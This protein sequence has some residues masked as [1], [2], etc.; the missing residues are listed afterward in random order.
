[1][2][3]M[4]AGLAET[5]GLKVG[6]FLGQKL[7]IGACLP[8]TDDDFDDRPFRSAL[9]ADKLPRSVDLRRWMT[10]VEAQGDIGSCTSNALGSA[11]EYLIYRQTGTVADVSRLFL[12]Y[13]QRLFR[14]KVREDPGSSI[15]LAVRVASRLGVPHEGMWPYHPDLFAVQPPDAVY[16]AALEHR[17]VDYSRVPV[18]LHS[19]RACLAGGFPLAFGANLFPSSWEHTGKTGEVKMPKPGEKDD[20]G[21]AMLMVG[22]DDAERV[23]VVRNSWGP[24]WGDGG[25]CYVPFDYLMNPEWVRPFWMIRLASDVTFEEAEHARVDLS[26]LPKA[27]PRPNLLPATDGFGSLASA[28]SA[29]E[30][31][32]NIAAGVATAA[33]PA[34][35]TALTG[36]S[37]AGSLLGGV[38]KGL[39]PALLSGPL[40]PGAL[41]EHDRTETIL[42]L[43]RGAGSP[44]P[45]PNARAS[46]DDGFDEQAVVTGVRKRA[47]TVDVP[48]SAEQALAAPPPQVDDTLRSVGWDHP[49]TLRF[50]NAT[51]STVYVYWVDTDGRDRPYF[52]LL[53]SQTC[54][55]QTYDGHPWRIRDASGQL[56]LVARGGREPRIVTV[57]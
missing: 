41:A 30:R 34:L 1:M 5:L 26:R 11:I 32:M 29:G 18:D 43:L 3:M 37:L 19:V 23:F 51:A 22:Y 15:Q 40:D 12:Y 31:P 8:D 56:L 53:P 21:H 17:V 25:Y 52:Q 35:I 50:H 16:R 36:S 33:A 42:A 46:W 20:G 45:A 14:G 47:G 54:D 38:M 9:A 4:G 44:A 6:E 57:G 13:N 49:T 24:E 10:P 48:A 2:S 39:A 7:V 27:P 55:Q 28:F